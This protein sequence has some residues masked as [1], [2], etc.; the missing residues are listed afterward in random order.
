MAF[1]CLLVEKVKEVRGRAEV[2]APIPGSTV[3]AM[4]ME[5]TADDWQVIPHAGSSEQQ[6]QH[7]GQCD[8]RPAVPSRVYTPTP[9]SAE[10]HSSTRLLGLVHPTDLASQHAIS[11]SSVSVP[12]KADCP[13]T[14]GVFPAQCMQ[15]SQVLVDVIFNKVISDTPTRGAVVR[16]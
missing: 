14:G 1:L 16:Q 13:P 9:A 2:W 15:L 4:S 11:S 12:L 6:T 8:S 10:S 3:D 7:C 5:G